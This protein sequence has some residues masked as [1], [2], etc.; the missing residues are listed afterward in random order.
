MEREGFLGKGKE[1]LEEESLGQ[2]C[3]P[4]IL[5]GLAIRKQSTEKKKCIFSMIF[6]S[7]GRNQP[8]YV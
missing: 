8:I 3:Y 1:P 6:P 2:R 4:N 5:Q 7:L